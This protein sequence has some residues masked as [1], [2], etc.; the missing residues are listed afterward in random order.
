MAGTLPLDCKAAGCSGEEGEAM[1]ILL[2]EEVPVRVALAQARI[3][4]AILRYRAH[5]LR[6][7]LHPSQKE[8][9]P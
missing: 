4:L 2:T 3:N 7:G 6:L 1:K 5:L 8:E 9:K